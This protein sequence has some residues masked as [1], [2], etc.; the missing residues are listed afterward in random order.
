MENAKADILIS[1]YG[2]AHFEQCLRSALNQRM[3]SSVIVCDNS[4][5]DTVH[6]TVLKYACEKLFY[7]KPE[8]ILSRHASCVRL[9]DM[10]SAPWVRFLEDCEILSENSLEKRIEQS[11]TFGG[12]SMTFSSFVTITPDGKKERTS[13]NMPEYIKGTDYLFN[14]FAE[15]PFLRFTNILIRRDIVMSALFQGLPEKPDCFASAAVILAMAEGN[16]VYTAESLVQRYETS[17]EETLDIESMLDE[18]ECIIDVMNYVESATGEKKRA[19]KLRRELLSCIFRRNLL[20]LL[21]KNHYADARE[22]VSESL[23]NDGTSVT[24]GLLHL[25]VI[26]HI[27]TAIMR[28][29][30]IYRK[31]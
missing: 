21:E 4:G 1:A 3:A 16:L 14:V 7:F 11:D 28:S 23:Q 17:S 5:S 31:G 30:R 29:L 18:T 22:Y 15:V 8:K 6:E 27:L 10:S 13:Y 9:L 2:S 12:I 20:L 24:S 25:S 26:S 19:A